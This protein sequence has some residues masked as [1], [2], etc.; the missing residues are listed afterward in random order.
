MRSLVVVATICTSLACHASRLRPAGDVRA[1]WP[2]LNGQLPDF[3]T[4]RVF[5]S[6]DSFRIYRTDIGLTFKPDV[7]DSAKAAFFDRHTMTVIGVSST[8]FYV[9]IPDPGPSADAFYRV[10]HA[11]QREPEIAIATFVPR[12]ALQGVH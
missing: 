9:R 2:I 3:D 11:L 4:S 7:T 12:D 6:G 1:A 10:L 5:I 8:H